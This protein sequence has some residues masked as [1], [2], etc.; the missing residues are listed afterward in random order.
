M[1][2]KLDH[3]GNEDFMMIKELKELSSCE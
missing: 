3:E 2:E 1:E